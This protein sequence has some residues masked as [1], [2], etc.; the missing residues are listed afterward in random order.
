MRTIIIGYDP[1]HASGLAALPRDDETTIIAFDKELEWELEKRGVPFRS[2]RDY[3]SGAQARNLALASRV[4]DLLGDPALAFL[5]HRGI[6]LVDAYTFKIQVF[7]QKLFYFAEAMS[8]LLAREAPERVL[9][10]APVSM[11]TKEDNALLRWE[12]MAACEALTLVADSVTIDLVPF[13]QRFPR[14]PALLSRLPAILVSLLG[15][16]VRLL[17]RK[18]IRILASD[19]WLNIEPLFAALPES[20]LLLYDRSEFRAIPLRHMF[21]HR[22]RFVHPRER[23]SA[24]AHRR[25]DAASVSILEQWQKSRSAIENA[26]HA[27]AGRPL[28]PLFARLLDDVC[29]YQVQD[30]LADVERLYDFLERERPQVVLLRTTIG[31]QPHFPLLARIARTLGI[32]AI[33]LQHGL[34]SFIEGSYTREHRAQYMAVYG[35][36]IEEEMRFAGQQTI[37]VPVGSPRF[38]TL[39]ARAGSGGK[40]GGVY[41]IACIAPDILFATFY[42]T[43]DGYDYFEAVAAA[44]RSAGAR[45]VVKLRS[46]SGR[47]SYYLAAIERAFKDVPYT[48]AQNEP[49]SHVVQQVDAAV[50]CYSTT[51]LELLLLRVPTVLLGLCPAESE[52]IR[53]HFSRY[54]QA[55]A[56]CVSYDREDLRQKIVSLK[57]AG[58]RE[59]LAQE[60]QTLLREH[61]LFDGRSGERL[62]EFVRG[63][64]LPNSREST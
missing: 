22:M 52:M 1:A 56:V 46:N 57:S 13:E 40:K 62:A 37:A 49:L 45:V 61:Y 17:P 54:A 35:P 64:S 34:E 18:S 4:T 27:Y 44:A 9:I 30:T 60:A 23:L 43:Y 51:V 38:D 53:A 2:S 24:E 55:G 28:G 33:E 15:L 12:L 5:T 31:G 6:A 16:T 11:V 29:A 47:Q 3:R 59:A 20:E 8:A 19:R 41:T 48:V 42:D 32:P 50:S 25:V 36:L 21:A 26:P 10:C 63:L 14:P 7:F 58:R 39:S